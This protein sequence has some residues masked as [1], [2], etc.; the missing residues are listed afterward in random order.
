MVSVSGCF[1]AL[2]HEETISVQIQ[3]EKNGWWCQYMCHAHI[4]LVCVPL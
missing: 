3:I 1:Y 4:I 2:N